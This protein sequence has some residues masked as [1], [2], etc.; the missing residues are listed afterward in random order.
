MINLLL[1]GLTKLL[2]SAIDKVIPDAAERERLKAEITRQAMDQDAAEIKAA[3][4]I[5][6]AEA[7]GHSWLQRNWRPLVM[8]WFAALVGAHWLG[9][10]PA[11][12]PD[13]QVGGLLDIVQI[14]IGG[15]T[16][17]RSAEKIMR[18]YKKK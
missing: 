6:V 15:Y 7:H 14:G 4:D 9:F 12:L 16:I 3:A 18:E 5:I 17:G 10:T 2:D 8:L 11:N 13:A 1:P